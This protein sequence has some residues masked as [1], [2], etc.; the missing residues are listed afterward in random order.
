MPLP[1]LYFSWV[2]LTST[3]AA[4]VFEGLGL[5]TS[6][7]LTF[8]AQAGG[9]GST[10]EIGIESGLPADASSYTAKFDRIGSTGYSLSSGI[11]ATI[12]FNGPL[13]AVRPYIISKTASTTAVTVL[14]LGN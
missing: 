3:G 14:L 8:V 6:R 2:D 4:T 13:A 11:S 9:S 12:Q 10:A 1:E 7:S 5:R